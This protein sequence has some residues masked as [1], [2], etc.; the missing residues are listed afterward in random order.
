MEGLP[1]PP[2]EAALAGNKVIGYTG[3]GGK[4]Y[5]KKPIF[6][7]IK[8]SEIKNFCNAILGNLNIKNFLE[9]TNNQRNLL[10]KH[11]SVEVEKKFINKFLKRIS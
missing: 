5:W 6:T 10:A 11:F 3:E 7:E 2:V 9:K 8:T 1:L 4:E